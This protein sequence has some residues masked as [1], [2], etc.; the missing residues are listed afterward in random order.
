[1]NPNIKERGVKGSEQ[2]IM[3]D[4]L[5]R[6]RFELLKKILYNVIR[7]SFTPPT[8]VAQENLVSHY[9]RN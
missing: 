9:V 4:S 5:R 7:T 3:S 1:M 2:V 6:A 8:G